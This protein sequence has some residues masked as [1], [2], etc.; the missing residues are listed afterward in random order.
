MGVAPGIQRLSAL[1]VF[2]N[3]NRNYV[4]GTQILARTA[5]L[6]QLMS[7]DAFSLSEFAFKQTT[8]NL[9]GVSLSEQAP[10]SDEP[11]IGAAIFTSARSRLYARF[12][13]LDTPAPRANVPETIAL[14]LIAGG[15][16]GNG[17][18][19]FAAAS[20]FE[21]SL[22]IIVQSVKTLHGAFAE[23]AHDIWLTGMRNAA[24]PIREG[25]ASA[26]GEIEIA[27]M[28]IMRSP[29]QYQTLSRIAIVVGA[30]DL[31]TFFVTFALRS[32]RGLSVH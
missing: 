4:Q 5:E 7:R 24:I 2:L 15:A 21:D 30:K 17:R 32:D 22:R 9:V 25:F 23:D 3:G 28:R 29:P 18:F 31:Q 19:S 12:V 27:L 16:D 8:L 14:C 13:D 20:S 11:A 10:E 6:I 26:D 1:D